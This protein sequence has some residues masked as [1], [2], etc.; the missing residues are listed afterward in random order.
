DAIYS[1]VRR[2]AY[3][4]QPT[5][6][7]QDQLVIVGLLPNAGRLHLVGDA[8]HRGVDRIDRDQADRSV[9]GPVLTGRDVALAG[10]DRQL[11]RQLGAVVERADDQVRIGD[12]D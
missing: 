1:P 5:R 4:V 7:G 2:V 3:Q 10:V 6:V 8:A 11:H 9:L 12:L